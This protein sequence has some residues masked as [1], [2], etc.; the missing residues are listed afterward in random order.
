MLRLQ[1]AG[2]IPSTPHLRLIE[3]GRA[4]LKP[5]APFA[6]FVLPAPPT[7]MVAQAV[8]YHTPQPSPIVIANGVAGLSDNTE[9]ETFY[10][11]YAWF[12]P[13][14][15]GDVHP[16]AIDA[17]RD[18]VQR[19]TAEI[20]ASSDEFQVTAP[21]DQL[22]TAASSSTAAARRLLLLGGE[23]GAL[24]LAFT[25][26]AAAA[27]RR[28][29]TDARRRLV[30]FG[31]RR[32]QVELHTLAESLSLAAAGTVA[33]W[34]PAGRRRGR[35][36]RAGSPVGRRRRARAPLPGG[37]L[38]AAGVAVTAGLLLYATVRAPAVHLGRLA[39]TPLD[40]AA[41]GAIAVVL[42]GWAR[43]SV[44]SQQLTGGSGTS[45]FLLLVPALIVFAA[46]V[47]AAGCS[48]RRCARSAVPAAAADRAAA[49]R[50]VAGPQPGHAAIAATF[51]VASLGLALFAVTYRSTLLRGQETRRASRYPRRSSSRGSLAARASAARRAARPYP[52]TTTPGLRLSGNVPSGTTFSFLALP[53]D[54]VDERR[55]LASTS[56]PS[57][58]ARLRRAITPKRT[59]ALRTTTLPAG[60]SFTLPVTAKGD[61]VAVR[62]CSAL[63]SATTSP[64]RSATR[65]ARRRSCCTAASHSSARPWPS[66]GSTSSP[67]AAS[68]NGG[69]GLQPISKGEI[70]S[71]RAV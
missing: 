9:L 5:D 59:V 68:A 67:A 13:I 24:L 58:S 42:V 29:V 17:F 41:L 36:P 55:R 4:V 8:R 2:P 15:G 20:E 23:G 30:W 54:R 25:I 27:L 35:R 11:S 48:R 66:S 45:A 22:A 26:L 50:S 69:L 56:P 49:G 60:R 53:A 38:A 47:V 34:G 33:G 16:W 64:S 65:T 70:T 43:G 7:E 19:L 62:A 3:V 10:R 31:A 32:W 18:K 21:T 6:P 28:D 63:G 37:L 61:D 1:G 46:A 71:A 39:V 44:D 52:G 51:L 12:V 14:R 57:R 40:A